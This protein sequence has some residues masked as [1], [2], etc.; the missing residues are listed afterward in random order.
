MSNYQHLETNDDPDVDKECTWCGQD[1]PEATYTWRQ[2][3]DFEPGSWA[4]V[5]C[6]EERPWK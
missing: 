4:C 5:S 1:D 6:M 2:P 3:Y